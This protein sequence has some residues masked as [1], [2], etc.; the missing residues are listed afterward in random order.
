MKTNRLEK[1]ARLKIILTRRMLVAG[2]M[3]FAC[4]L[5]LPL[6]FG[7]LQARL[8][9]A[10]VAV[11]LLGVLALVRLPYGLKVFW[12]PFMDWF[13]P[14]FLGRR[15]GWLLIAQVLLIAV[16]LNL[17]LSDPTMLHLVSLAA[18]AVAFFSASQDIVVDAYRREDLKDNDDDLGV[19]SSLYVNC[20]RIA[21]LL[22]G[23][24]ALILADHM[25]FETVYLIM[26]A[27]MSVGLITTLLTPEPELPKET[28]KTFREAVA[29]PFWDFFN[30]RGA[31]IIMAF[32]MLYKIGDN[33]A[34]NMT[35]PFYLDI[36]FTKTQIGTIAKFYG[37]LAIIAGVF[38]GGLIIIYAGIIKS[39]W[40]FGIL[41]GLSTACFAILAR[42]GPSLA[43]LAGVISFENFST[44]LGTSAF[45]AFMTSLTNK[46][47][48]ATQYA[49]FTSLMAIPRDVASAPTGYIVEYLGYENFFIICALIAIPGLLL[50]FAFA[51]WLK[52]QDQEQE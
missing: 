20:Y 6:V 9:E 44:G 51:P 11:G 37:T 10:G 30:R 5:P 33:M 12:A 36:G 41:Q 28:P 32:I 42:T 26:V 1:L 14:P 29:I 8:K 35:M 24:G 43:G 16:T 15:R 45:V 47:F 34:G 31:F 25:S 19:G 49:L 46:K 40:I 17:A 39:L 13:I 3:G 27:C 18:L 22:S 48:T 50:I 21:M 4:G 52:K 2:L 38:V 7:T 23:G